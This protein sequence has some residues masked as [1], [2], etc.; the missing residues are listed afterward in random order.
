MKILQAHNT[1]RQPGGE[2][3]VVNAERELLEE[4]GH[5][6]QLFGAD[7]DDIVGF[8][9]RLVTAWRAP[10]DATV[11]RRLAGVL[12]QWRPDVVH[13]HNF[14]PLLTPSVFEACQ[15][16]G[17]P[18]VMTLHNFRL[19]CPGAYLYRDGAI[20]ED[21]LDASSYRAVLHSCYRNSFLGSLAVARMVDIH[22]RRQTWQQKV[23]RFIVMTDFSK[24]KLLEAGWDVGQIVVKTHFSPRPP[25]D[26]NAS[27]PV[28]ALFA[29]RLSPEKG[30]STLLKAWSGLPN[31]LS[32]AGEGPLRNEVEVCGNPLVH[33]LGWLSP[34]EMSLQ[35]RSAACLV[36]PSEWY[37]TFG[38]VVIE[39]FA[40]GLPVIASRLGSL[41]E[42]VND[43]VT[44]LHFEPGN[45]DDLR[46]KV[47]WLTDHPEERRRMGDN[48]RRVY[49]EKYTPER[50]YELLLSIYQGVIQDGKKQLPDHQS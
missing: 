33:L 24:N 21:C 30:I 7:N 15:D 28:G 13:V 8:W 1:Y 45:A 38:M 4:N 18:V 26:I 10:F 2:D 6:V 35:L 9:R 40:H 29:G 50:N 49:E 32:L 37:E 36:V 42:L 17:I 43:G 23:D 22:R 19:L 25:C 41:A 46:A 12:R 31:V 34:E 3:Q 5:E 27:E 16:I 39:A 11:R 14:F 44:G 47:R 20:C 48:A